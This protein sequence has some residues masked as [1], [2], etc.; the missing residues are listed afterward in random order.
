MR[1]FFFQVAVRI[2]AL[3]PKVGRVGA[4]AGAYGAGQHWAGGG[5]GGGGQHLSYELSISSQRSIK[6]CLP[7]IFPPLKPETE[8]QRV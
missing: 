1:M 4:R 5:C 8:L 6:V 3:L 2:P 7:L